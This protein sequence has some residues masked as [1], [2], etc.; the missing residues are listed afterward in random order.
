MHLAKEKYKMITGNSIG[1]HN[2]IKTNGKNSAVRLSE[3]RLK[4]H[5]VV[6]VASHPK[7]RH[8]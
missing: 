7:D 1:Y 8:N 3:L 2:R 4:K 5:E 6:E